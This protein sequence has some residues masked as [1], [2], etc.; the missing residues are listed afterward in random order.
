MARA[1]HKPA[2]AAKTAEQVVRESYGRFERAVQE[3]ADTEVAALRNNRD[4]TER[5]TSAFDAHLEGRAATQ[6]LLDSFMTSQGNDIVY[7]FAQE[8]GLALFYTYGD[9]SYGY[10]GGRL[11]ISSPV[12]DGIDTFL[13]DFREKCAGVVSWGLGQGGQN[14]EALVGGENMYEITIQ[15]LSELFNDSV[16]YEGARDFGS[17]ISAEE[18]ESGR[19]PLFFYPDGRVCWS[20]GV[21]S[22]H[23][24]DRGDAS[25]E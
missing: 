24:S 12:I 5:L 1:T 4:L 10:R 11:S 7:D 9:F 14:N 21:L 8:Q 23:V 13:S 25:R 20:R 2:G 16:G 3:Q 19:L 15:K 22:A 18:L 17:R 6:D